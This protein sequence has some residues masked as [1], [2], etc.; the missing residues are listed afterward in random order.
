MFP[1]EEPVGDKV[2]QWARS[3]KIKQA[4]R[5]GGSD[6]ARATLDEAPPVVI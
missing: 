3:R 2:E 1:V 6:S 5:A 4:I